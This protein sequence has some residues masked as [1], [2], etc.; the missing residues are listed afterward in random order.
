MFKLTDT[1]T[2]TTSTDTTIS[3]LNQSRKRRG[4]YLVVDI[5][6]VLLMGIILFWGAASQFYN[7]YNDATRYQC[8]AVG[9]WQG[10][11]GLAALPSKQCAFL[12][13]SS[14]FVQKLQEQHFPHMLIN[15]VAS[16]SAAQ[17]FHLL[18]PEYP[19]LTLV[20]FSL[21]LIVPQT[22]YWY[23]IAFAVWMAVIAGLLYFILKYYR[24]TS[25]ALAFALYLVLGNWATAE[26]RFDLIPAALTLGA[27]VLVGKARWRWAFALL[28][29]ATLLKFYPIVLIP[30]LLIAQQLQYTD[31]WTFW[32]R[33]QA[34]GVFL[35]LCVSV[36]A[37]SLLLNVVDTLN[38]FRY[39][40]SRPIQIESFP[41]VLVWL[42]SFVG[43]PVQYPFTFQSQ[44]M[45][46]ALSSK[47][48]IVTSVLLAGGLLYTFWLQWQRKIDII[49]SSLLSLLIL[50]AAGKVLSP[51]YLIWVAPFVAYVGQCH[52]KW[53]VTWGTVALLTTIIFPFLYVDLAH[54]L[55]YYPIVVMRDL[56]IVAT[57]LVLLYV[58]TRM[59]RRMTAQEVAS[60]PTSSEQ[61]EEIEKSGNE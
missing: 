54:I 50:L 9:F 10:T 53:L 22:G 45:A 61:N 19:V 35:A 59:P 16:Q 40:F 29:L 27:V 52:W 44:N 20:P 55:L 60:I 36:T 3:S 42:G 30:P 7:Q 48:G 17:P 15:L 28:A 8:Y 49:M 32:R 31:K 18:P 46:S 12:Q 4:L 51:Q 14:T 13:T 37:F 34:L 26:A 5:L 58:A 2:G 41:A 25:A 39:F 21:G 24:S 11:G 56:L 43:Y 47:I 6:I 38:P 57:V 23:Q 33:W 1:K